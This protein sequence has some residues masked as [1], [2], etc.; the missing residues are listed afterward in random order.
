MSTNKD[1]ILELLSMIDAV[2]TSDN[3]SAKTALRKFMMVAAITQAG[4]DS[5]ES[6]VAGPVTELL[7]DMSVR[8]SVLERELKSLRYEQTEKSYAY[9]KDSYLKNY[10]DNYYTNQISNTIGGLDGT[11]FNASKKLK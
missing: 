6:K 8:I 11:S 10:C 2:L 7:S 5:Q 1:E 3:E 9:A 4:K